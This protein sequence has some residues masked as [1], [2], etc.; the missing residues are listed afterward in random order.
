VETLSDIVGKINPRKLETLIYY[1]FDR[2]T[3]KHEPK[4]SKARRFKMGHI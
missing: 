1:V 4:V 3:L 2:N